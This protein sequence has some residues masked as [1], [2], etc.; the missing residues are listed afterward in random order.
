MADVNTAALDIRCVITEEDY[1]QFQIWKKLQLYLGLVY[2]LYLI[3]F[4]LIIAINAVEFAAPDPRILVIVFVDLIGLML[5]FIPKRAYTARVRYISDPE[6]TYPVSATYRFTE[7]GIHA[8][9]PGDHDFLYREIVRA[10]ETKQAFYLMYGE[11]RGIQ[12]PKRELDQVTIEKIR[13]ILKS[14]INDLLVISVK[15]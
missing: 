15:H 2:I 3:I 14:H 13:Q 6:Y 7:R 12:I 10:K 4:L 1:Y 8:Q 5:L 11:K 9:A